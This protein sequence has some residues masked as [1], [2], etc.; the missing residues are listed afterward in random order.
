MNHTKHQRMNDNDVGWD[1]LFNPYEQAQE[2]GRKE[3]TRAGLE[4][5]Y[6]EGYKLGT[7]YLL[8]EFSHR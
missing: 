8:Y 6:K 3:G 1:S 2:E 7:S 5:G 4:S